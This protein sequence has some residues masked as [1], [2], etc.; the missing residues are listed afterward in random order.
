M[1]KLN[2]FTQSSLINIEREKIF[3]CQEIFAHNYY[4]FILVA[5]D[6]YATRNK[7]EVIREK[8]FISVLVHVCL[9]KTTQNTRLGY[10]AADTTFS[11]AVSV[12]E[13]HRTVRD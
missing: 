9:L 7:D 5:H 1:N 11:E 12:T 8:F 13:Y 6:F 3:L 4:L 2:I 10:N